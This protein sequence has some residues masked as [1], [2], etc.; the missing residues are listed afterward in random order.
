MSPSKKA[1]ASS[2]IAAAV[3]IVA[4]SASAAFLASP[5]PCVN[6]PQTSNASKINAVSNALLSFENGN[7]LKQQNTLYTTF[8]S[9]AEN[10]DSSSAAPSSS[11]NSSAKEE[12]TSSQSAFFQLTATE[13]DKIERVVMASCGEL[14]SRMATANAQVILDRIK[15]G[16]FGGSVNSVLDAPNQFESPWKG[17]VNAMVK[18][19]VSSV[20][21][22]GE[23]ITDT[24]IYYYVN[25]NLS[26]VSPTVWSKDKRYVV[27]IGHGKYIHEYWTDKN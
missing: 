12:S 7:E 13:R 10:S 17:E 22:R 20:F 4:T 15:S 18:K 9:F 6:L 3:I 11:A 21:D 14:D 25:P 2:L 5:K 27:T 23:R 1:N 26:Y 16:R 19:A 24:S 8:S